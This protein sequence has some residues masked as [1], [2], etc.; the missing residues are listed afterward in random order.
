MSYE[1]VFHPKALAEFKKLDRSTAE[2]FK[3][4]LKERLEMPCVPHARLR[5]GR[6]MY[7]IKL[8]TVGC[9]LVYQVQDDKVLILVLPVG[10]R[11]RNA[12]YKTA[13]ERAE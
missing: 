8:R 11:E 7:K 5:G 6:D 10:K 13:L 9:R 2:Q 1:L 12:A 4:K 3:A